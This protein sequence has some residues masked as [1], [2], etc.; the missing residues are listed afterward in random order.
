MTLCLNRMIDVRIFTN[1]SCYLPNIV[2]SIFE[3][4]NQIT[5]SV[6]MYIVDAYAF[7]MSVKKLESHIRI[8]SL[9]GSKN[10]CI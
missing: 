6:R 3:Q 4:L 9:S 1:R 2:H 5:F 8:S 7:I 10:T